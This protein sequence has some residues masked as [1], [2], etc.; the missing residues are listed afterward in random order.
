MSDPL[1][2]LDGIPVDATRQGEIP[3]IAPEAV[4][5]ALPNETGLAL[6]ALVGIVDPL[7]KC[8]QRIAKSGWVIPVAKLVN[9]D[10]ARDEVF[11]GALERMW[12]DRDPA[13][14]E[15]G[16]LMGGKWPNARAQDVT[17]RLSGHG[18]GGWRHW[19]QAWCE[20][21]NDEDRVE[22]GAASSELTRQLVYLF[23]QEAYRATTQRPEI[24]A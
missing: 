11:T 21:R 24:K 4:W 2:T 17:L 18:R 13:S 10:S 7:M 8:A 22:T 3:G 16:V 14:V 6:V 15:F 23:L 5:M 1:K 12:H 19:A 20:L 9:L